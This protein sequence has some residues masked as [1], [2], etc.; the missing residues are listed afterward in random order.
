MKSGT[1]GVEH[2]AN[3]GERNRY[4]HGFGGNTCRK[5]TTWKNFERMEGY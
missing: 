3:I 1:R 2:S 5:E 4:T